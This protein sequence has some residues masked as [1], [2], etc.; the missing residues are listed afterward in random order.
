MPSSICM[1]QH[2]MQSFAGMHYIMHVACSIGTP[3][4]FS[5]ECA[6]IVLCTAE[7]LYALCTGNK[8]NVT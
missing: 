6:L 4:V 5:I 7:P 1:Q 8:C 3:F 2:R